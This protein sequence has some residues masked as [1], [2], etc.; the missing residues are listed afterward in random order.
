MGVACGQAVGV[1]QNLI[2]VS[3]E[4]SIRP[5]LNRSLVPP[6]CDAELRSR[7]INLDGFVPIP[8]EQVRGRGD[9]I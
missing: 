4:L 1:V 9:G 3:T 7:G 5:D 2:A 6:Y 8:L